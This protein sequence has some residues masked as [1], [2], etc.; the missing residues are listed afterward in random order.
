[1]KPALVLAAFSMGIAE[2]PKPDA[3][4][5][6]LKKLQGLWQTSPGGMEHRTGSQIVRT[7][8]L[9][10]PC[11]FV[12]ED[13]LIWLDDEGKPTG[14]EER[15]EL[16]V[17]AEPMRITIKPLGKNKD[18]K[19]SHGIFRATGDSLT[20]HLGLDGGPAP[21]QFLEMNKPLK[22]VDGAEW[23]VHRRKLGEK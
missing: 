5:A 6:E 3:A 22:G 2:E 1:M 10:G 14:K 16:D 8:V 15:I 9:H 23:L 20:I 13:R 18:D 7:P 4:K 21:K 19:P 11:F 12:C 17:K